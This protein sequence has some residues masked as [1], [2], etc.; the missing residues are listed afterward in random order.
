MTYSIK[1]LLFVSLLLPAVLPSVGAQP[2]GNSQNNPQEIKQFNTS[3]AIFIGVVITMF[4][5]IGLFSIY[6]VHCSNAQGAANNVRLGARTGRSGRNTR[7]LDAVVLETFPTLE[8]S[9]VKGLK[10]GKGAL[11]CAVCLCEFGDD[12]TLRLIPKCDHVF[13]PE[14][15]DMWLE[16][17]TT[18]PV[19][20]ANLVPGPDESLHQFELPNETDIESQNDADVLETAFE[21]AI[22]EQLPTSVPATKPEVSKLRETLNHN[23]TRGSLSS[24]AR[25]VY[26]RSQSLLQPSENTERFT[27]RLP[28]DVRKEIMQRQ[29]ERATSLLEL[30]RENNSRSDRGGRFGRR[31]DWLTKSDQWNLSLSFSNRTSSIKSPKIEENEGEWPSL[32]SS[33]GPDVPRSKS[34]RAQKANCWK[35]R[36]HAKAHSSSSARKQ[37][38]SICFHI[39]IYI[40][41]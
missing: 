14:C 20:R 19:C 17:H 40:Y 1:V 2:S 16:S 9:A 36:R 26:R 35:E 37:W 39:N 41:I 24:R 27:L 34:V 32:D 12:E 18:C 4:F 15:V 28:G 31:L 11:E 29:L 5:S 33:I 23:R 6:I 21:G 13:H 7:G 10:I 25:R 38:N 30:P 8:Y 22:Q 3:I